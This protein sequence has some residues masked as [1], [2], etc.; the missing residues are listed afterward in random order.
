MI[1]VSRLG[2]ANDS[3]DKNE[4]E[5]DGES[6]LQQFATAFTCV[7]TRIIHGAGFPHWSV[8][9]FAWPTRGIES[10]PPGHGIMGAYV[11]FV[12]TWT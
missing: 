4:Q 7:L 10:A 12:F 1:S 2:E 11:A 3:E 6:K 8:R 9:I 5:S